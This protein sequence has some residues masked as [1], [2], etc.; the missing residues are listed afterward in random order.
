M[1]YRPNTGITC[2]CRK[3]IQRDNCIN[4]E[5]TGFMIA[6]RAIRAKN[7]PKV[8][9]QVDAMLGMTS[10]GSKENNNETNAN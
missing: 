10:L 3:G 8:T 4:C 2:G 5:G 7:G 6:F 1:N 9:P